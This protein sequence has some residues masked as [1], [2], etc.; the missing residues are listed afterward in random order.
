MGHWEPLGE[1][2]ES[3]E[4]HIAAATLIG[5]VAAAV[6]AWSSE[7][8]A[9]LEVS[10]FAYRDDVLV[11]SGIEMDSLIERGFTAFDPTYKERKEGYGERLHGLAE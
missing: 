6:P 3:G 8:P 2:N 10:P 5:A 9:G 11:A 1:S 7:G 4:G